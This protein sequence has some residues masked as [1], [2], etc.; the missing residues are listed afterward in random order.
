MRHLS[1]SE[2]LALLITSCRKTSKLSNSQSKLPRSPQLACTSTNIDLAVLE[3]DSTC[4]ALYSV[5]KAQA[6][7]SIL[8]LDHLDIQPRRKTLAW[9]KALTMEPDLS[10]GENCRLELSFCQRKAYLQHVLQEIKDRRSASQSLQGKSQMTVKCKVTLPT[11][12]CRCHITPDIRAKLFSAAAD[13]AELSKAA[14]D[15]ASDYSTWSVQQLM[16]LYYGM[17]LFWFLHSVIQTS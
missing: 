11:M 13:T 4:R 10:P 2:T 5:P 17:V 14:A 15:S 7:S 1:I 16:Q 8:L 12:L 9:A 3:L 6:T